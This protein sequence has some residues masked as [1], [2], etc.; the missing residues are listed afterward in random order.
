MDT[1]TGSPSVDRRRL[2]GIAGASLVVTGA[3]AFTLSSAGAGSGA[4]LHLLHIN[5]MHSRLEPVAATDGTCGGDALEAGACF[6][7]AARLATAIRDRR[8]ALEAQGV[9]VLTLDAGDQSQ[10]TLFYTAHGGKAEIEMMNLIGF[11]AMTL[12]NH[13]F[14]RG[15]E[16]LAE[17]LDTA[18][19]PIV[20]GNTI[21]EPGH[22]LAALV[23]DR[24]VI[25]AEGLRVG[26][27]GVTTPDTEFLS[28]PGA[29]VRFA[30]PAAHLREAA[31]RL[32]DEGVRIVLV[33]SHLGFLQDRALAAEVDGISLIIGGHSHTLMSNSVP[34]AP[35]YATLVESPSGRAVPIVQAYAFSRYL[36]DL[37]LEFDADGAVVSATGDTIELAAAAFPEAEDV[38]ARVAAL[39]GP[40][41]ELRATPVAELGAGI[42]GSRE[43][44]RTGECEMGNTVAD[45]MLARMAEA[46]VGL[47]LTNGGGLRASLAA[48]TVT[49][50]DMLT[51]LPFQNTL[52]TLEVSGATLVAALEHGVNG[53][54]EGAGRFPQVAGLRFGLDL[55]V[56]PDAGRVLG[57]EVRGADG[58]EPLDP[59][60]IYRVV[61]NSFMARGGDGYAMLMAEGRAGYDTAIDLA[62]ALAEYLAERPGFAP[63]IDGRIAR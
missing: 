10:G 62:D 44:C 29:A 48:G 61:T 58:W 1:R 47:A 8:A 13:E 28:S 52:Y 42:D 19:F 26:I 17:M 60:A 32:R 30:D 40:I 49:L 35:D 39:A 12:G 5:D 56:P 46:G 4:R 25:E 55:S 53:I 45:A 3:G 33:L 36:G 37:A 50:G 59:R 2:L 34:G 14:N 31:A 63:A 22:P 57:V 23:R 54:A 41:A 6:G 11:D 21:V 7:G 20:S 51:V 24:L 27:L 16:A 9:P 38:A 15:P 18:D 43:S